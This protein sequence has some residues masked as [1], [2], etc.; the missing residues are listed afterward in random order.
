MKGGG[1]E[2]PPN[3]SAY[4]EGTDFGIDRGALNER[5]TIEQDV[6]G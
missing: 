6:H 1:G 3:F 4:V 5:G 2:S